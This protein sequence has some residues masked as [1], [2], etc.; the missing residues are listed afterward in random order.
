MGQ[1]IGSSLSRSEHAV[2]F[3]GSLLCEGFWIYVIRIEHNKKCYYYVGRTGD[4]SSP[5]AGS[6]FSRL[7]SHFSHKKNNRSSYLKA[8][9][10]KHK[11][12]LEASRYTLWAYGPIFKKATDWKMH[13]LRRNTTALI[14][15]ELAEYMRTS[16][17]LT[18]I[19]SYPRRGK[20]N[21]QL[22]KKII[23]GIETITCK[24]S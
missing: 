7:A 5:S 23:Q 11:I 15:A 2:Q 3:D 12:N 21:M 10:L 13:K 24:K 8:H 9:F 4:S 22:F 18:V 6:P 19:G 20:Y 1:K 14:E 16:L 17:E